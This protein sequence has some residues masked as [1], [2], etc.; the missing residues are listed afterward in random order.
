LQKVLKEAYCY[1]ER[2]QQLPQLDEAVESLR[3]HLAP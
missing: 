1:P 2:V 3:S